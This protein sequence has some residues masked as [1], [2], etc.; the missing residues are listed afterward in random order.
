M[1]QNSIGYAVGRIRALETN[2]LDAARLDRLL[3]APTYPEALRALSEIGWTMTEGADAESVARERVEKACALVRRI[4]PAPEATDCFLLRYDGLNLKSLLKAR[5]LGQKPALLSACGIFPVDDLAHAV[6]ER[7]YKKLPAPLADALHALEKVLAVQDDALAIDLAVD[8]GIAALIQEKLTRVSD[9]AVRAYFAARADFTGAL[10]LLRVRRM[11]REAAFLL[12]MLPPGGTIA[13]K[14][15]LEAFD[16]PELLAKLLAPYGGKVQKAA[17]QAAQDADKLPALE[18]AADDYLLKPFTV[19]RHDA[20]TLSPVIGHVL[21]AEREAA[22]VRLVLAG[23]ANGF[24]AE[25]I[26]ER[27]RDLYGA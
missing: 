6:T 2:A 15:W 18:K 19:H 16:R 8:Q 13:E 27:L 14:A 11:G 12:K 26:R 24:G 22:A 9:P 17:Q 23:K 4:T 25:A 20:L 1:P 10:M 3:A 21:G 5:C 7:Q